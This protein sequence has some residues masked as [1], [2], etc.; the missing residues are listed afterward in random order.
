L[1]LSPSSPSL[2]VASEV[3]LGKV[4]MFIKENVYTFFIG[5]GIP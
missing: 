1:Q 2:Y 4:Q 5:H 3:G